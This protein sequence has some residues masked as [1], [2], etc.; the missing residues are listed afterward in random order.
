[1]G[2]SVRAILGPANTANALE[3]V[4]DAAGVVDMTA[5]VDTECLGHQQHA[6]DIGRLAVAFDLI[7]RGNQRSN[8]LEVL[9]GEEPIYGHLVVIIRMRIGYPVCFK[10]LFCFRSSCWVFLLFSL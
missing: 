1:M 7:N 9:P 2:S 3:E 8:L 4:L 10:L 6:L 5:Q